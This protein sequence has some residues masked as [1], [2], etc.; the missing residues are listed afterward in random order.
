M[1]FALFVGAANSSE[2][3]PK[4]RNDGDEEE[5]AG[6]QSFIE[7]MAKPVCSR[8]I[9]LSLLNAF[10]VNWCERVLREVIQDC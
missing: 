6:K 7:S 2:R 1:I 5:H 8:Y 4:Q 10:Y 9:D 3:S